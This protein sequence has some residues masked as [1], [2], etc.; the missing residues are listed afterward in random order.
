V[1][2]FRK[3]GLVS[4]LGAL[5]AGGL[6]FRT[7]PAVVPVHF[8]WNGLPDRYGSRWE[9]A[10]LVPLVLAVASAIVFLRKGS[11]RALDAAFGLTALTVFFVHLLHL[12]TMQTGNAFPRDAVMLV[13]GLSWLGLALILPR[14]KRNRWVGVRVPWTLASDEVWA[15]THRFASWTFAVGGILALLTPLVG[16]GVGLAGIL[17]SGLAPAIYSF[18]IRERPVRA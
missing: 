7:L 10:F 18:F 4:S 5:L 1:N 13:L 16:P 11:S 2:A 3:I 15:R 14:V 12:R 17:G 8:S 6:A 9:G